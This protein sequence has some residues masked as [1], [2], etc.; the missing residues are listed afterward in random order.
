MK[1]LRKGVFGTL[2][3][4]EVGKLG[5]WEVKGK[6]GVLENR[7]HGGAAYSHGR[8]SWCRTIS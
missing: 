6:L 4:W 2:G 3:S 5:S 7:E 1:K 8:P